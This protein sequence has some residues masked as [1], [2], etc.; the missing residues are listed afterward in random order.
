MPKVII[1]GKNVHYETYGEGEPLV[2]LNGIMM[3]TLSWA[4]FKEILSQ[5]NKLVLVDFLDMGQSDTNENEYTQDLHVDTLKELFIRLNFP[6]VHLAGVSY[7]GEVAIRFAL[8]HP[9]MV[10][11]LILAN[12]TAYTF[13]ALKDIGRCWDYAAAT[14][15]GSIFF[16]ATMPSIYSPE[17]YEK[18]KDELRSREDLFKKALTPEW[19]ESFRRLNRSSLNHDVRKQLGEI[20]VPTLVIGA[21]YDALLPVRCQEEIYHGIKNSNM[22]VIKECGHA[23]MYEKPIEFS[24]AILGFLNSYDKNIKTI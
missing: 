10:S 7:G 14:H 12:T 21:E 6:K 19:Y 17:F 2:L 5:N 1:D 15:D 24:S 4:G 8:K 23:A 11:S 18:N 20:N 22:V 13:E 3:S 16:A 9:N